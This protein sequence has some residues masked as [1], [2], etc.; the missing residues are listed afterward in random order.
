[1]TMAETARAQQMIIMGVRK[2]VYADMAPIQT[3][4]ESVENPLASTTSEEADAVRS[5]KASVHMIISTTITD[6]CK[7]PTAII[8]MNIRGMISMDNAIII[9]TA[10]VML[11]AE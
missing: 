11:K 5:G 1:M 3:G 6:P 2:P 9:I 10:A 7:N 4:A 8:R